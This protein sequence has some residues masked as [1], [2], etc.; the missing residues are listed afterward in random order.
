MK[1]SI[2]YDKLKELIYFGLG[3]VLL[4]IAYRFFILSVDYMGRALVATSALSALIGFTSL[5]ASLQLFR[6][7]AIA[8]SLHEGRKE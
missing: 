5:V 7:S 1:V 6:L 2:S 3:L 8:R 4:V